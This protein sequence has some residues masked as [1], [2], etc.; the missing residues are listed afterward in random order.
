MKAI[1]GQNYVS[2]MWK[3]TK[4]QNVIVRKTVQEESKGKDN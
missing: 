2:I 4:Q 3:L 1:D